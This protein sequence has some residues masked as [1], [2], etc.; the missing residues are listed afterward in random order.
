MPGSGVPG[1]RQLL[2]TDVVMPGMNG[3][4]LAKRLAPLRPQMRVLY[5]SGHTGDTLIGHD[6][7]GPETAFLQKPFAPA[8]LTRKVREVLDRR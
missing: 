1:D 7:L 2:L 3:Y 4:E 8:Q 6:G 5:V